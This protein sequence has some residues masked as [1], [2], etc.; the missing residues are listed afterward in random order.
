M[1]LMWNLLEKVSST[2]FPPKEDVLGCEGSLA[3]VIDGATSVSSER[4]TNHESDGLWL[5][6]VV[7]EVFR[8]EADTSASPTELIR[9][10]ILEA[11]SRAKSEWAVDPKVPPSAAV[12]VVRAVGGQLHYAVLADVSIVCGMSE[13][14]RELT[15]HRPD[16]LNVEAKH[17]LESLLGSGEDFASAIESTRLLLLEHRRLRMNKSGGYWVVALEVTAA[18]HALTGVIDSEHPFIIASDGFTRGR[19]LF[20]LWTDWNAALGG[21]TS[22]R[23]LA[24]EVRAAELADPQ[25]TRYPRWSVHDDI[26]AARLHWSNK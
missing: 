22:L 19:H 16:D 8:G 1:K 26:V 13:G 3:W 12:G 21:V 24:D 14:V 9:R 23:E 10:A 20:G 18:D 11:Q 4:C 5:V 7:E 6:K 17:H 25:C 2:G 15:D